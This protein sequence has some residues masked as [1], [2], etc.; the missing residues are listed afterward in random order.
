MSRLL[1]L[2]LLVLASVT[3]ALASSDLRPSWTKEVLNPPKGANYFLNWGVGEGDNEQQATNNA[4]ANALHKSFHELGVVG[5]TKQ[6]I[7]A[8]A[9]N[10]IDAVI[11]FH[12]V[13]RRQLCVTNAIRLPNKKV[14]VYVLIQ[15][16]RS[17]RGKDDFY[18]VNANR[19]SDSDF[20]KKVKKHNEELES[21]SALFASYRLSLTAPFGASL[22]AC[23]RWGGYVQCSWGLGGT[24]EKGLA[25]AYEGEGKRTYFRRSFTAGGMLR[26]VRS[27]NFL[28]LY[29]GAGYGKYGATY[30]ANGTYYCPDLIKGLEVEGGVTFA[31][32]FLNASVGYTTIAGSQFRE[33]HFG[34]G[35]R[36]KF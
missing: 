32:Q 29:A 21:R 25:E 17:I 5:I 11:S 19:C 30:V 16:Q 24:S 4:W 6:D 15:V 26:P 27:W 7:E 33:I 13:K 8:V 31:Y 36:F 3:V 34:L 9:K 12:K 22:G 10:G 35:A 20:E 14:R 23:K 28:Y 18:E 1:F 2:M